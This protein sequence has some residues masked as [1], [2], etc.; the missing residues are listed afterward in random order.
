MEE[1]WGATEGSDRP[2]CGTKR[3]QGAVRRPR[4]TGFAR[5][6]FF[7]SGSRGRLRSP[8]PGEVMGGDH[9][10]VLHGSDALARARARLFLRRLHGR[11]PAS[12]AGAPPVTIES[13]AVCRRC[14][15]AG[16]GP[17]AGTM[18]RGRNRSALGRAESVPFFPYRSRASIGRMN[19]RGSGRLSGRP[20]ARPRPPDAEVP[21][22]GGL[23]SRRPGPC[24]R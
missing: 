11:A 14:P 5:R 1:G 3:F 24:G 15:G 16:S 8:S 21:R 12:R 9:R 20:R 23:L 19:L 4:S 13:K 7:G 2:P 18:A 17:G 22:S 6:S 10:L